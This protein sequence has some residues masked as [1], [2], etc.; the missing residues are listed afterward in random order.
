MSSEAGPGNPRGCP[1]PVHGAAKPTLFLGEMASKFLGNFRAGERG[2]HTVDNKGG[3]A[4]VVKPLGGS[5]SV[6]HLETGSQFEIWRV[7]LLTYQ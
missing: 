2:T 6:Y 5:S 3:Q 7:L 1:I 4:G